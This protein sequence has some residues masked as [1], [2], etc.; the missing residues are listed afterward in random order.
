MGSIHAILLAGGLGKRYGSAPKQFLSLAG[1]TLL[2]RST[3][4]FREWGF[5]KQ[6]VVVSHPDSIAEVEKQLDILLLGNDRIVEGGNT[7]HE[8]FLKGYEA[9]Q[10]DK[11]D[12]VFIHD[13]ARPFFIYRELD[14]LVQATRVHGLATLAQSCPDTILRNNS[15][16]ELISRENIYLI[17]TPQMA[18]VEV[19]DSFLDKDKEQSNS[20]EPT[21]LSSWGLNWG[22]AT[23]MVETGFWNLKV[24]KPGDL[25]LAQSLLASMQFLSANS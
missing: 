23:Q 4:R 3:R 8:S 21:D 13:I 9:I 5:L 18:K 16:Q 10:K 20:L 22:R 2:Q 11:D 25:E 17:K 6:I 15:P 24:T 14:D 1:E 7:R 19:I 12:L